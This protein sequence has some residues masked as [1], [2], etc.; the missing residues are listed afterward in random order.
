M[1]R[2]LYPTRSQS[3]RTIVPWVFMPLSTTP[4]SPSRNCLKMPKVR[5][6]N[7]T[8]LQPRQMLPLVGL[9]LSKR[10]RLSILTEVINTCYG[11]VRAVGLFPGRH[12]VTDQHHS[13]TTTPS[14][15]QTY[16]ARRATLS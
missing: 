10:G 7:S 8:S 9:R 2:H 13:A 3:H 15:T 1:L 6:C 5:L 4:R 11:G 12:Q 14:T 16:M